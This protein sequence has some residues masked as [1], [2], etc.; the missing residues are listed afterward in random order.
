M[1]DVCDEHE[2]NTGRRQ[3]GAFFAAVAFSAKATSGFGTVIAGFVLWLI[4]WPVGANIQSAADPDPEFFSIWRFSMGWLLRR[5]V[6]FQCFFIL[7][8]N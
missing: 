4:Q 5:W 7:V 6:L 8:I 2:Y 1:A 3:E